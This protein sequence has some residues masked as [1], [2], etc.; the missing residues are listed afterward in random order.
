MAI[1]FLLKIF[2]RS[3]YF[4]I[5]CQAQLASQQQQLSMGAGG[6]EQSKYERERQKRDEAERVQQK[7]ED[8]KALD[9]EWGIYDSSKDIKVKKSN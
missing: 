3:L 4:H 9:D 8:E 6:A 1:F 2:W 5:K 7:S